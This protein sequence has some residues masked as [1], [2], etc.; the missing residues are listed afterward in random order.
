MD[1]RRLSFSPL[2]TMILATCAVALAVFAPTT[3]AASEPSSI[4]N[5]VTLNR[6]FSAEERQRVR[7]YA[8]YWSA[9]LASSDL[10][11]ARLAKRRLLDPFRS[12][13]VRRVFRDEYSRAGIPE[14]NQVLASNNDFAAVNAIQV[15][16]EFGNEAALSVMRERS[17]TA[18]EPR[19]Q[20]RLWASRGIGRVATIGGE[21][22]PSRTIENALRDLG[23]AG[24]TESHWLVLQRQFEAM[25]VV[26]GQRAR[27]SQL[28][29]LRTT[30][31]RITDEP[32]G[33]SELMQPVFRSLVL[34]RNQLLDPSLPSAQLRSL[35][36]ELGPLLGKVFEIGIM[37]W[38]T[39]N[40]EN[41]I[42]AAYNGS[43]G[44]AESLL[45]LIDAQVRNAEPPRTSLNNA[46]T[47]NNRSNFEADF[48][49]WQQVLG[50]PPYAVR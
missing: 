9:A 13:G 46:W 14:L 6:E 11:Q 19:W 10:E 25:A 41:E 28:S 18:N 47:S 26:G 21:Q 30:L 49:R 32:D 15:I 3:A 20:I 7:A 5:L 27:E 48:D 17:A 34:L 40:T 39:A 36:T 37:H 16:A 35:G 24:E 33:P 1:S 50:G 23:R 38:D 44:V 29:L 8:A 45:S 4:N 42:T 43:I 31:T 22:I 12:P 2:T